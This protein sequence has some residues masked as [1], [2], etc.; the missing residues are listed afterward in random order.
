MSSVWVPYLESAPHSFLLTG[1]KVKSR[2]EL[3]SGAIGTFDEEDEA[4]LLVTW[5]LWVI[6]LIVTLAALMDAFLAYA[7][8]KWAHPWG[9]IL[10]NVETD[11]IDGNE[12]VPNPEPQPILNAEPLLEADADPGN[13]LTIISCF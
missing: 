10:K 13:K 3:L 12:A 7:Y 1:Y 6:P 4:Y 8:M 2:H 11:D 9:P 5:L